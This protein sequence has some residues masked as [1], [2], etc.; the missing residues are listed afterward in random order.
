VVLAI[1]ALGADGAEPGVLAC[2]VKD[3][4]GGRTSRQVDVRN[5][6]WTYL[7][8]PHDFYGAALHRP[9]EYRVTWT[10][11]PDGPAVAHERFEVVL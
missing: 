6:G 3:P 8:Y 2:S 10:L 7:R 1:R 4:E 9:G 11:A 5:G